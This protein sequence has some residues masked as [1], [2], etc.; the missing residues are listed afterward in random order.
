[1]CLCIL[2]TC[3]EAHYTYGSSLDGLSMLKYPN[4]D[5]S[6]MYVASLAKK[7]YCVLVTCLCTLK[8][9]QRHTRLMAVV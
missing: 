6:N 8:R 7:F 3:T 5:S 1:M 9:A 2:K 4:L